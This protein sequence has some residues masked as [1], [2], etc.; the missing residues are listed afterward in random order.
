MQLCLS[1]A[2]WVSRRVP[3]AA[4]CVTAVPGEE[5]L[6]GGG[7]VS[8]ACCNDARVTP[9]CDSAPLSMPQAR[10][11][12]HT[13]A[14][15]CCMGTG[16]I[17]GDGMYGTPCLPCA[18]YGMAAAASAAAAAARMPAMR[19]CLAE[20]KRRPDKHSISRPALRNRRGPRAICR[21]KS[22]CTSSHAPPA[23]C[24]RAAPFTPAFCL[25]AHGTGRLCHCAL[26]LGSTCMGCMPCLGTAA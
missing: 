19:R 25:L 5:C 14:P 8:R 21:A 16:G 26:G 1:H 23:P 6:R 11:P 2:A 9:T 15:D 4:P 12:K 22:P 7:A 10:Q 24:A 20:S 13:H 3:V 17:Q 18:E